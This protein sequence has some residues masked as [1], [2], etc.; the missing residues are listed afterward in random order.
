MSKK[1]GINSFI[2]TCHR[3]HNKDKIASSPSISKDIIYL[4]LGHGLN[5]V[6]DLYVDPNLNKVDDTGDIVIQS[7]NLK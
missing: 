7:I 1:T 4:S 6:T 5:T 3:R 2:T